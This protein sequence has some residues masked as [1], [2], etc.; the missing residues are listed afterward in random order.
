M[1][2]AKSAVWPFLGCG[3]GLFSLQHSK[4]QSLTGYCDFAPTE[5]D[6]CACLFCATLATVEHYGVNERER[7]KSGTDKACL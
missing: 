5:G 2:G 1:H 4:C 7:L 6:L 3:E